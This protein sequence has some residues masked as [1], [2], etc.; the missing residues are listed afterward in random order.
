MA[1][2]KRFLTTAYCSYKTYFT[3]LASQIFSS[4]WIF[5]QAQRG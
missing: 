5:S 1:V 3:S 4:D 2:N